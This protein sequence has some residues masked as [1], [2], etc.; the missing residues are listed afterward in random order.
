METIFFPRKDYDVEVCPHRYGKSMAYTDQTDQLRLDTIVGDVNYFDWIMGIV[1]PRGI[2]VGFFARYSDLTN[3]NFGKVKTLLDA[4]KLWLDEYSW[5]P[6]LSAKIAGG[7][8][9]TTEE[10][11]QSYTN[12]LLPP[13]INVLGKKPV[14]LSYSYGNHTFEDGVCPTYLGARNS[15]YGMAGTD[16]GVGYGNPNN[17]P[18]S[19]DNYK[20]RSSTYRWYDNAKGDSSFA[21]K[22]AIVSAKIDETKQNGGWF[23]NFTHFDDMLTDGNAAQAENYYN[24]LQSKNTDDDIWFA[25]YGEAV[26]YLVY[27]QLITRAVMYSP[28]QYASTK[29]VIRLEVDNTL[30]I[31]TDLL[32]VPISIKFSTTGTP[33][34]N[35]TLS[36]DCNLISLGGGEYIVEIPYG[37]GGFPYAIINGQ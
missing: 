4:G 30:N 1:E 15:G 19:F 12:T 22:L 35:K 8:T 28:I 10:F 37:Q 32:Q 20:S 17:V 24:L 33:L 31:D 2:K 36:S 29:L 18:Y 25:G 27:R 26:A 14:C 34:A 23:S 7:Q 9:I 13:F 5:S 6:E 11:L 16:Y 21:E 3:S